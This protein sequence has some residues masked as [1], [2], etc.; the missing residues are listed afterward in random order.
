MAPPKSSSFSVR[1]VLPASGCEMIANVRLLSISLFSSSLMKVRF[2]DLSS[3]L[4]SH[5]LQTSFQRVTPVWNL[6]SVI[7]LDLVFAHYG[8]EGAL[9]RC[10][11]L[12]GAYGVYFCLFSGYVENRFGEVVPRGDSFVCEMV[13]SRLPVLMFDNKMN[14]MG[15]VSGVGRGS[16]LVGDNVYLLPFI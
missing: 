12:G 10:R 14:C 4:D 2:S 1:V 11:I 3:F 13:Y 16:D 9:S 8:V 5:L 6:Q 15:E 7:A